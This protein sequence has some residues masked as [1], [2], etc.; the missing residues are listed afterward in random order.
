MC[1]QIAKKPKLMSHIEA[2]S[3]PYV[4]MTTWAAVCTVGELSEKSAPGKR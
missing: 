3:L 2:A 4:A 1:L